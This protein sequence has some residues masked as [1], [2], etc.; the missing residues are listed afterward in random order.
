M[1]QD[2]KSQSAFVKRGIYGKREESVNSEIDIFNRLG[3]PIFG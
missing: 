2:E 1:K 3:Y